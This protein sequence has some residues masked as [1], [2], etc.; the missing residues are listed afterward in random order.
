MAY[1]NQ[2]IH[3]TPHHSILKPCPPC[4]SS[5]S[6][7]STTRFNWTNSVYSIIRK[8]RM[9]TFCGASICHTEIH[10]YSIWSS[11]SSIFEI[12][13]RTNWE[14]KQSNSWIFLYREIRAMRFENEVR[15][16]ESEAKMKFTTQDK[17]G[18]YFFFS[19]CADRQ[20][21]CWLWKLLKWAKMRHGSI[22][23]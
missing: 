13:P 12:V 4:S 10:I 17:N 22:C 18:A 7:S 11:K 3:C 8:T 2:A 20:E 1:S 16:R 21:N 5:S 6:S 15:A 14:V 9:F 23:E 19:V